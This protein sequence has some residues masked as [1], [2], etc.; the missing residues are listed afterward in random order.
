MLS[1]LTCFSQ[2]TSVVHTKTS[3]QQ[4][5]PK[6][7]K[8]TKFSLKNRLNFYPFNQ[9][10][11][12][13]IVSF[14]RQEKALD[15]TNWRYRFRD[16]YYKDY[17]DVFYGLP[18]ENDTICFSKLDG[19]VCLNSSQISILSDILYNACYGWTVVDWSPASCYLPHNAIIFFD[20][21]DK[22]FELIE[23]C[24]GCRRLR[25]SSKK[26]EKFEECDFTYDNLKTYFKQLG[27]KTALEDFRDKKQ[28]SMDQ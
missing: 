1:F 9:S 3:V 26:I 24:F 12:I 28:P 16:K 17:K 22:P 19:I 8:V 7:I 11:Q 25:Y 21:D 23:I 27:L 15:S 4:A 2:K 14:N 10:N 6:K 13:K 5:T 18:V 20:R